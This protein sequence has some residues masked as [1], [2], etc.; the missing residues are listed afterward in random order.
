MPDF[1][2]SYTAADERWAEWIAWTLEAEGFAVVLQKWDFVPGSNF[3]LEMQRA[4]AES[5]K[6]IAVLS[7]AYLATSRFGAAEWASAFAQDPDGMTKA[8][9]P[10]RVAECAAD[11]LLK[12]IVYIDLIGMDEPGAKRRLLEAVKGGRRKPAIPPIFPGTSRSIATSHEF[13][14]A[15]TQ[16]ARQRY[17]PT[18][19]GAITDA[20]RRRFMRSAFSEI[21]Q[22]FEQSMGELGGQNASIQTDFEKVDATTFTAEIFV[23]GKSRANCKIWI[24]GMFGRDGIAYAEGQTRLSPT[25]VNE[26]LVPVETGG[27]LRL[28]AL[29]GTAFF[30]RATEGLDL[31]NLSAEEAADYL[32][33]RFSSPLER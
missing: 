24:G 5:K 10:V 33:R 19:R 14:G 26:E 8:L 18:I 3:V 28:N 29:M 12:G 32:W 6:T 7:P 20:D 27:V 1:F 13:P 11:G 30:G 22:M 21:Q 9:I 17:M 23:A 25:A 16:G 31:Q 2:V 4:A 15:P